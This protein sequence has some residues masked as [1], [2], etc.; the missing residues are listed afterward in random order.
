VN[1]VDIKTLINSA[2]DAELDGPRSVPPWN[3]ARLPERLPERRHPTHPVA[4][5]SVPALAASV[6][7]LL[8]AGTVVA[9]GHGRD[10]RSTP[11]ANSATPTPSAS[12]SLSRSVNPDQEA[13]A[14]A[15]TEAVAGAREA[16]EVA[17]VTVGPLSA[18]DAA[19]L[20]DTSAIRA[21]AEIMAPELGK[22]YSFTWSYL[23]GP[24]DESPGVVTTEVRDVASGSCPEPFLARPGHTYR[25][26]C[27]VMLLAGATGKTTLTVRGPSGVS[28]GSRNLTDPAKSSGSVSPNQDVKAREYSDALASAPEANKVAGVSDQP[29]SGA[30]GEPGE[31]VGVVYGPPG[32]PDPGRSYPLTL[33]Y[34][35]GSD[36][37]A[38]SVLA[39]SIEDVTASRCPR[40]FRTRPNHSYEIRCQV[41]F[42]AGTLGKAYYKVIGP[43]GTSTSGLSITYP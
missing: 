33:L 2:V 22:T 34:V 20:K 12:P 16:T 31:G 8:A 9:I 18:Q 24:S 30:T 26:R 15:Y 27:Q 29:A 43:H 17:G 40:A 36:A 4:R 23:A 42:R 41:T 3:P 21:D 32:V 14:R 35:S 28:S 39:I 6:A 13:A 38:I 7:A 19:W 37:P 5:W 11:V 10:G 1:D 25:I